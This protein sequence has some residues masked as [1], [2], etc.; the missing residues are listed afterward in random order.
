MNTSKTTLASLNAADHATFI[1]VCGPLFEHSPWI[2]ERTYP[3][4]PFAT[5]AALHAALIATVAAAS[6]S[7]QLQLLRAHP[8]LVGK[9]A[10]AGQLTAASNTEQA[11]AGLA[12][13]DPQE[14]ATFDRYNTAYQSRF[15]FPFIICAREN[16]KDAILRAFPSRLSHS[17]DEEIAAALAEIAK[18]AKLRLHDAV[19]EA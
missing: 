2:A 14:V 19:F 18:I 16:K 5:L 9:L 13:L 6:E 1:S 11:A 7:E 12:A 10:R 4:R 8:D 3:R 15:G 17:R